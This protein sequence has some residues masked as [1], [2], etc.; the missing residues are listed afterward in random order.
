MHE[1]GR[2]TVQHISKFP[3]KILDVTD[4]N[5]CEIDHR[6]NFHDI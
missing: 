1:A 4:Q 5:P 6:T 3:A 2:V